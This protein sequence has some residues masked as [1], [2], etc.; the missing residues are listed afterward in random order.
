MDRNAIQ[1]VIGY[2]T[3]GS[4]LPMDILNA[5][6]KHRDNQ[7]RSPQFHILLVCLEDWLCKAVLI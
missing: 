3:D 2:E 5:G 7:T 4:Q 1:L 6:R